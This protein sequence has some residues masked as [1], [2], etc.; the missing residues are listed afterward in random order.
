MAVTSTITQ[1]I[2]G[3]TQ[4]VVFYNPSEFDNLTY[5]S[6]QMTYAA[7]SSI[8]LSQSDFALWF[9]QKRQFYNLL[10]TNFPIINS[11]YNVAA[12]ICKFEILS[13][14]TSN[15]YIIQYIQ[16]SSSSPITSVYS[17]TYSTT[18]NTATFAVRTNPITI[19]MQEFLIGFQ[20]IIQFANQ[21]SLV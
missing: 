5:N 17:I 15:P 4:Q 10:I 14:S 13:L 20:N 9:L 16:T 21:C 1:N 12:P 6:N 2:P 3:A 11:S 7:E 18:A 19:T 8:I